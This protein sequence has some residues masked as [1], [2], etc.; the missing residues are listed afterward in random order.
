MKKQLSKYLML[1]GALALAPFAAKAQTVY[2]SNFEAGSQG[3]AFSAGALTGQGT[4]AWSEKFL[5]GHDAGGTVGSS[6]SYSGGSQALNVAGYQTSRVTL[7]S[8]VQDQWFEFAFKPN[9]TAGQAA[10]TWA[11]T[12]RGGSGDQWGIMMGLS[13]DGSVGTVYVGGIGAGVTG[14]G[15]AIGSFTNGQ[16]QTISFQT[17]NTAGSYNV[18]LGSGNTSLG[19]FSP[20]GFNG[21]QTLVFS[22]ATQSW[23]NTGNFY[24]DGI[25]VGPSRLYVAPANL[26]YGATDILGSVGSALAA[27]TPACDNGPTAFSVNP[28]LP[29][30]LSL[31]PATGTI[32]G[33]PVAVSARKLYTV[34][35]S[36]NWGSTTAG[37]WI[38]VGKAT[39]T[40]TIA[41]TAS[42]IT[43]GQALSSSTLSGGSASVSG[44]FVWTSPGTVPTLSGSFS[45]TFTPADSAN[46]NSTATTAN[47]TVNPAGGG[48]KTGTVYYST[49][50]EPGSQGAAF[51]TGPV[52]GQGTPAWAGY[53]ASGYDLA[54]TVTGGTSYNG[55]GQA[56]RVS[57]YSSSV[58]TLPNRI[59]EPV[60][61]EFAFRPNFSPGT[62][63]TTWAL[64]TRGDKADAQGIKMGLDWD[65]TNGVVRVGSIGAGFDSPGTV[66]GSFTNGQWQT[67]SFAA[68]LG[69]NS[70]EVYF[71]GNYTTTV[72][73]A[74]GYE[75]IRTLVFS[76]ATQSWN[77]TGD[78]Q[79]DGIRLASKPLYA[80][81][82][83]TFSWNTG[84]TT[85]PVTEIG[86]GILH[87]KFTVMSPRRM[88]INAIR[89]DMANPKIRFHT[90]GRHASWGQPMPDYPSK[91]IRTQ[92]QTT[93]DFLAA[94]RGAGM[95]MVVAVNAAPWEPWV[96]PYNHQYAD[97]LGL[98]V[99][100]GVLV[101]DGK[102]SPS[103]I[104]RK[105]GA[106]EMRA[107]APGTDISNIL[108]AVSGFEF[109]LSNG[110]I[111]GINDTA[112]L[113]PRTSVG[114]SEDKRYLVILTIDGRRS[115]H[116]DGATQFDLGK[117]LRD[118]GAWHG[119]NM[120]GGGSTT[121]FSYQ[122]A[123]SNL[124]N[125]PSGSERDNGNNLGVYYDP[126]PV[127]PGLPAASWPVVFSDWLRYRDVP[128][129]KSGAADDAAGD[130]IPNLV[131]YALNID[132]LRGV[133]A[134]DPNGRLPSAELVEQAGTRYLRFGWRLNRH[135]VGLDLF[136][137][138]SQT[139]AP[140]SWQPL[141]Q[142]NISNAG[143]DPITGDTLYQALFNTGSSAKS[144]LRLKAGISSN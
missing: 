119:I 143:Q 91:I 112:N 129:G 79:V 48:A 111:N 62:P 25:R 45:V 42:A 35:A 12:T 71:S 93:R 118:F 77:N 17:H 37:V 53:F 88:A 38:E 49:D 29:G 121:L 101:C 97:N 109:V 72:T 23:T 74:S 6:E 105:D 3:S 108:H 36:N 54:G 31:D 140:Q 34:T 73:V 27:A 24:V 136:P 90:T 104:V 20:A 63:G 107:T 130:G 66:V 94:S 56:M 139:L 106:L 58:L 138:Y 52:N 59:S 65:G 89:V 82:G 40:V 99:S 75:G 122:N 67:I 126:G 132:P 64:T 8:P 116:S 114:L 19:T 120:D 50:F 33:T 87:G 5:S 81:T 10:T 30:G 123:A 86:P 70:Y 83:S 1:V 84:N 134:S 142:G 125:W 60:W 55:G 21:V 124:L 92:R 44:S 47:V 103:F 41:P 135:A 11:L 102:S 131:K 113:N 85:Y 15:T 13:W 46:Y 78:W 9:F 4:P 141:P 14:N 80:T 43:Y 110:V 117:W 133:H 26:G 127:Q 96:F 7:A 68:A 22:S 144:F 100:N 98:A 18:F 95:N 28:A 32:S 61:F 51:A 76:S 2:A 16:W 57:G 69:Q 128:T 137:E 39:P 115:G